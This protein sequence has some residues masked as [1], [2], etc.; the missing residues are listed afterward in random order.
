MLDLINRLQTHAC[1]SSLG[2]GP[3]QSNSP[4]VTSTLRQCSLFLGV[5]I[6]LYIRIYAHMCMYTFQWLLPLLCSVFQL[7][8]GA[9][10]GMTHCSLPR[11]A[12]PPQPLLLS[13]C[14]GTFTGIFKPPGLISTQPHLWTEFTTKLG[15]RWGLTEQNVVFEEAQENP[16]GLLVFFFFFFP[17]ASSQGKVDRIILPKQSSDMKELTKKSA[18]SQGK[19]NLNDFS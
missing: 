2:K 16:G 6:Y 15:K 1:S 12:S 14:P 19:G 3:F 9:G 13:S 18:L 8:L 4:I 7:C 17:T 10:D 5:C 11:P